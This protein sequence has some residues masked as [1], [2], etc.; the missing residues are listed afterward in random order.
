[1]AFQGDAV[2]VFTLDPSIGEFVMTQSAL[3]IPAA[4][5]RIYSINEGNMSTAPRSVQCFVAECKAGAKPY[6]LRY[7]GS[8]VA[9]VHRTLLYGGV[10][11]YPPSPAAPK[12]KLRVLYECHPMAFLV[13][14]AG[15]L[16]VTG[17]ADAPGAVSRILDLVP[18]G[19]HDKSGVV[20]GC[21]RDVS[22]V[23]EL[24]KSVDGDGEAAQ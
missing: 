3:R 1:M 18:S 4:P 5:Q 22:R 12:G 14:H 10:F 8:M 7:T 9:D 20:L 17:L 19:I 11:L 15:G 21:A 6:S 2:N 16:A 24:I 23:M 13:E